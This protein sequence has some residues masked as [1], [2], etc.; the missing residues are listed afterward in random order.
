VG[1][2]PHAQLQSIVNGIFRENG[3]SWK[4]EPLH[5]HHLEVTPGLCIART[6]DKTPLLCIDI[7]G[8]EPLRDLQ[9]RADDYGQLG[10]RAIW[11]LDPIKRTGYHGSESGYKQ[12]DD[13]ILRVEGTPIQINLADVFKQ[14]DV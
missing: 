14:L 12:P 3:Q 8:D 2:Q 13:G 1:K 7:L 11:L 5:E 4:V 10:V 6:G 9:E